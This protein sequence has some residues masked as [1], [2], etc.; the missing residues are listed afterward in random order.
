M[1]FCK[2]LNDQRRA[3][4]VPG[5]MDSITLQEISN[6]RDGKVRAAGGGQVNVLSSG[7]KD[8]HIRVARETATDRTEGVAECLQVTGRSPW[9][10]YRKTACKQ[11]PF[12]GRAGDFLG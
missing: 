6:A 11:I 7:S 12:Q 4:T 8:E 5:C 9:R 3:K 10:C 1:C 2:V